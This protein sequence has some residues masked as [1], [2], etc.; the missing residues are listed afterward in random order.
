MSSYNL[1]VFFT[2]K[3]VAI[4]G[5][6]AREGSVGN[7]L[8]RNLMAGPYKDKLFLINPKGGV[9]EG[10]EMQTSAKEIEGDIDLGVIAVAPQFVAQAIDDLGEK[11][12]RGA[13]VITAGLGSGEGSISQDCLEIAGRYGMRIVG[14]NCVGVL[15]PRAGLNASFCHLPGQSGDLALLSQSG[16]I[17]T[18]V[19]DWAEKHHIGFSGLVS[20]GDK[21]DVD[22]GDLIDHFAMDPHTRAILLYIESIKDARKFMSSARAA[23][24]VKPVVLIKSGRHAD[25]A[26]AAASHTGALAGEDAV[27]DAAFERAGLLRVFDLDEFFDAVETLTHVR[28]LKGPK[29]S[30]ITNGGGAGV[31]AVDDLVDHNGS[32]ATLSD[33]TIAALD[34]VLPSTWS[35]ANPVDIIGDAGA[36]RY[37]AALNLVMDDKNSDAVLAMACPTALAS[38]EDAAKAVVEVMQERKKLG[39]RRPPIFAAWLG[40]N[41]SISEIFEEAG[42]PHYPTPADAIRGFMYVVKHMEAQRTLMRMPPATPETSKPDL[43]AAREVVETALAKGKKW[44]NAV[45]ITTLLEAY[46]LPI[47]AARAAST[48]KEA[49]ELAKPFIEQYGAAVIKIDSPDIQHKSDVGGVVLDLNSPEHVERETRDVMERTAKA[50]P[51]ADIRGV[52]VHPMVRKPHAIELIGG[53]TVDKLFGPV[54]VFGRGGTAVE[55]IRDKALALPPLDMLSARD[56]MEKTRVNRLLA[57]YRNRPASD[58]DAIGLIMVK[59]SQITADFPEIQEVDFNPILADHTGSVITDARVRIAPAEKGHP[60]KR[61]AIK[62]YPAEWEHEIAL[63]DGR[64]VIVRPIR[65]EDEELYPPFFEQV[66]DDDLRLRFFSAARSMNHAF[67]AKLTQLDYARSMAFIAI[68]KESGNMLGAVRLHGDNNHDDGEYAVMVRSDLKGQGLGWKLMKLILQFAE[69]DGFQTVTGE[70]LR[71]NR[72]MRSMCEA[73]GFEAHVDP[74]DEDLVRMVFKVPNI[75]K[76]ICEAKKAIEAK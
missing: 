55:V 35:G 5:A 61:F 64:G 41:D 72:T 33:E 39:K 42:I 45:E 43:A 59:L 36:E 60:H 23:A 9:A 46:D 14:P 6:S 11:G 38:T 70:V 7:I 75:S 52:T 10:I 17:V 1:D 30:I 29:L 73:L 56:M 37:K 24:R 49:A 20:M 66:T 28:K 69:K 67:I 22:F 63:K 12:A 44:L 71:G 47:A 40:G 34:A 50:V 74:D 27:Y 25:G 21:A 68:E 57:G 65:P 3:N 76:R 48:P 2:P 31:L 32:L 18:A 62:P 16:A 15:S 54:M 53:M 58:R 26:R 13:V 19:V 51:G 8:V 4:V